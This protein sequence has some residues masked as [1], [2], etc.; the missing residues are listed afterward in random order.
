MPLVSF[1][2]CFYLMVFKIISTC[3]W[4]NSSW[5]WYNFD[6]ILCFVGISYPLF[7]YSYIL[8]TSGHLFILREIVEQPGS[9]HIISRPHLSSVIKITSKRKH[10]D[11]ITF[12][13]G[14]SNGNDQFSVT[15]SQRFLI[16]NSKQVMK[17]I[18][19]RIIKVIEWNINRCYWECW[20]SI[21][22]IN[23]ER[24]SICFAF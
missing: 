9:A 1:I 8:L 15:G 3:C 13:Y 7:C 14:T 24:V 23:T 10:P 12:K 5:D 17:K 11:L 21:R 18:K 4:V 22:D 16:P 6:M 2:K 19:E 20:L